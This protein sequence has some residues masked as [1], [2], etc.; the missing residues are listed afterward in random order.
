MKIGDLVRCQPESRVGMIIDWH[1]IYDRFGDAVARMAVVN[2]EGIIQLEHEYPD[3]L[4]V[5]SESR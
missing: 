1:I 4:E 3:M 5:I 2:W